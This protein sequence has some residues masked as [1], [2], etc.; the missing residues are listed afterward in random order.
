MFNGSGLGD[1]IDE[2]KTLVNNVTQYLL[3][4]KVD[5][6]GKAVVKDNDNRE[7]LAGSRILQEGVAEKLI[8]SNTNKLGQVILNVK[9]TF[10]NDAKPVLETHGGR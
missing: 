6:I 5:E 3:N 10:A 8:S 9:N 4:T 1:N 2:S 7:I